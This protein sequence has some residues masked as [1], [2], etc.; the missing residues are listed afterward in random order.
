M[1][2]LDEQPMCFTTGHLP[3]PINPWDMWMDMKLSEEVSSQMHL[4]KR[5]SLLSIFLDCDL[6]QP[7]AKCPG[8]HF[9]SKTQGWRQSIT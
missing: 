1:G 9:M 8:C 6:P 3:S 5:S 7:P 2:L 4:L